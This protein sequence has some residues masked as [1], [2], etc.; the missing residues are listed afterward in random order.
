[1]RT[2]YLFAA[3][4]TRGRSAGL[5]R[6]PAQPSPDGRNKKRYIRL[7]FRLRKRA[8]EVFKKK[9]VFARGFDFF[10]FNSL[11]AIK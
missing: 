5:S 2:A 1:M 3:E 10:F 6:A 7:A 4:A 11:Y 8:G 9:R